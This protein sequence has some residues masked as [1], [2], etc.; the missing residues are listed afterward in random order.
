MSQWNP[1][2][3]ARAFFRAPTWLYDRGLGWLLTGRLLCLTHVGR[4]SGRH[5][6]TVLE[7]VGRCG[8]E[9]YVVA[10]FGSSS[11]WYRNIQ[12][13][14]PVEVVSGRRRFTPAWR[15]LGAVEA[16]SV[17]ADYE[18]RNMLITPLVRIGLS[19]LVGWRY[20]GTSGA[21]DRLVGQ[22]PLLGF[23]PA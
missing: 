14:P 4:K 6:K 22:L 3:L 1:G 18:R 23:R 20:D 15:Q 21:R 13:N 7:V 5:Y 9:V 17:I 19:R 2:R 16:A 11:D 12:T 10:G 8:D